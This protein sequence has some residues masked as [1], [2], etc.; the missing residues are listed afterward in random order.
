MW[1][2]LPAGQRGI[3][4]QRFFESNDKLEAYPTLSQQPARCQRF[5]HVACSSEEC[6]SRAV[7]AKR[8]SNNNCQVIPPAEENHEVSC[9][10]WSQVAVSRK[11]VCPEGTFGNSP[12]F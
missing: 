12:P 6:I 11:C 2:K 1:G 10:E 5:A 4:N 9:C 8:D 7:V 3:K